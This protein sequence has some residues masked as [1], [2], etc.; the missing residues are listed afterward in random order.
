M[1]VSDLDHRQHAVAD[2]VGEARLVSVNEIAPSP[3]Q[4][5]SSISQEHIEALAASMNDLGFTAPVRLREKPTLYEGVL[6]RYEI[7]DGEHRWRAQILRGAE[8]VPADVVVCD[9][10]TAQLEVLA[11]FIKKPLSTMEHA[12]ALAR[13]AETCKHS[14]LA[15]SSGISR[16][17]VATLIAITKLPQ[18]LHEKVDSGALT[19]KHAE[20]LLRLQPYMA[21]LLGERCAR[22]GWSTRK[23]EDEVEIALDPKRIQDEPRDPNMGALERVIS[24]Q[25]CTAVAIRPKAN[26]RGGE[27]VIK[28]TDPD[29][30]G[31]ILERL[32][33]AGEL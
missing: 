23:L 4:P 28:F 33:I 19:A 25:L 6:R 16:S 15:A 31:G 22:E 7:I 26:S 10:V 1:M 18:A 8:T 21:L 29:V 9:D 30:L 5:R 32:G 12:R 13:A 17:R 14:E 27:L 24:E 2:R 11:S 20:L 3:Y